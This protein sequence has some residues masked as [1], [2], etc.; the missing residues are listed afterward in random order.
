MEIIKITPSESKLWEQ[1]W[2][3][4]TDS[5]PEWERR[6]ISS[7][8]RASEDDAFNTYIA[9]DN[10]NLMGLVFYW[11]SDGMIYIEHLAVNPIMRG[12]SIG[13]TIV[14]GLIDEYPDFTILLEIDPPVD[15]ISKRRLAFYERL[16]FVMNDYEYVHPSY[17]K[18]GKPHPLKVLS[19]PAPI[20]PDELENFKRYMAETVMKYID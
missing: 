19:L 18:N 3:L 2:R 5:F 12:K 8:S 7:H 13:S 9:L 10:G 17:S 20:S 11:K 6:R 14:K 1:V 16:G 15:E 4:Y